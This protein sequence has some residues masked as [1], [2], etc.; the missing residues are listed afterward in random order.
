MSSQSVN[1]DKP[2]STLESV[3]KDFLNW[4]R[5]PHRSKRIPE[6]LW[7][8]VIALLPHYPKSKILNSLGISPWQLVQQLKCRDKNFNDMVPQQPKKQCADQN[9]FVK[10][11]IATPAQSIN[12]FDVVLT[13]PNGATLQIHK[14]SH[15]DM[16]Q[17]TQQFAG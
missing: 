3:K 11:I 8:A 17:L 16:L 12:Y 5:D 4:R 6:S 15:D 10:A 1:I 13:K 7:D 9:N 2:T 14:L